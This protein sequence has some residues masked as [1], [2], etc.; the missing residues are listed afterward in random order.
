M[1]VI[2]N[3]KKNR[4][5]QINNSI[6]ESKDLSWRAKGVLAYLLSRPDFWEISARELEDISPTEGRDMV[7]NAIREL[8][9]LGYVKK[10]A[11]RGPGGRMS[12]WEYWVSEEPSPNTVSPHSVAPN[13]VKPHSL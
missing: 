7:R 12:G 4:F 11:F 13:S 1:P 9:G 5:V 10:R 3:P 2:R 6:L 8:E